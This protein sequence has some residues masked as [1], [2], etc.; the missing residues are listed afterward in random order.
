MTVL[1]SFFMAKAQYLMKSN[2]RKVGRVL[3]A[4]RRR[5]QPGGGGGLSRGRRKLITL[6]LPSGSRDSWVLGLSSPPQPME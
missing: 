4:H 3:L 1:A 6:G 2:L 5:I